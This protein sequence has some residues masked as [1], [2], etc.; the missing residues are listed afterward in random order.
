MYS[1]SEIITWVCTV[2]LKEALAVMV[3]SDNV[4]AT[5]AKSSNDERQE[6]SVK[7]RTFSVVVH[8]TLTAMREH[9][10]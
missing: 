1:V 7:L 4:M 2:T 10:K 9:R 5:L 6:D 8:D 3:N